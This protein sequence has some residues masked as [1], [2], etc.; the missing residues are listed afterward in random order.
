MSAWVEIE[1]DCIP[2]R[3]VGR[4]AVPPDASPKF[5]Q[6][7]ER[8]LAAR[9]KHGEHNSYYLATAHCTYHLTNNPDVGRLEFRFEGVVLT[10][11]SDQTTKAT[12]LT[13]ELARETCDW[14]TEPVSRWFAASVERAVIVEFDR[15]IAAGDLE[16]TLKRIE[17]LRSQTEESGGYVGM[18]L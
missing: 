4:L 14:L 16:K 1:F 15:Y 18:Y 9:Q 3:T 5:R 17:Q 11:D 7:C 8:I 13:V 6:R 12:D 10:D 2:L